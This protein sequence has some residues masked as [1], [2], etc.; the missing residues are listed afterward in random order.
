MRPHVLGDR[1]SARAGLSRP[2]TGPGTGRRRHLDLAPTVPGHAE[3]A[4]WPPSP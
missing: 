2:L 1:P 4:S 3:H